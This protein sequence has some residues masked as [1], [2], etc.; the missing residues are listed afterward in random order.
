MRNISV[1]N[2][3]V[4]SSSINIIG[5]QDTNRPALNLSKLADGYEVK[6]VGSNLDTN[7]FQKNIFGTCNGDVASKLINIKILDIRTSEI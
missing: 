4:C 7:I 2:S 3:Q 1:S 6:V 5:V